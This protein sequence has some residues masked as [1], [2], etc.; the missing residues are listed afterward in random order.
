MNSKMWEAL[1]HGLLGLGLKR[2]LVK[3]SPWSPSLHTVFKMRSD[4][5]FAEPNESLPITKTHPS[6]ELP[7]NH[8]TGLYPGPFWVG[9]SDPLEILVNISRLF[10]WI[11]QDFVNIS[12]FYRHYIKMFINFSNHFWQYFKLLTKKAFL[13]NYH[14]RKM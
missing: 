7:K 11:F 2:A 4:K 8:I 5:S 13:I 9:I 1:G 10:W 14:I 6:A 12:S 3:S